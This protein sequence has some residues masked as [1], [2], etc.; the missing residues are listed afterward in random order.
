MRAA[1][2]AKAVKSEKALDLFK[3]MY[4]ENRAEA[5]AKI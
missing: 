2:V 3:Q 1:N 5:N 4:G